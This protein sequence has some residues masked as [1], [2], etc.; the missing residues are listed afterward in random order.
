[1][2]A[3]G[4]DPTFGPELGMAVRSKA[5]SLEASGRAETNLGE[6]RAASGDR[7][8]TTI[9]SGSIIS[10]AHLGPFSGCSFARVGAFQGRAPQVVAPVLQSSLFAALGLRAAYTLPVGSILALRGALEGGLPLVRTSLVIDGRAV[11]TSPP[12]FA[13]ASLG[14]LLK[15]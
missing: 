7:L 8:E 4:P 10:C 1:S 15:F 3:V 11:W 5:L 13:G 2:L 12:V 9:L 6:T 14:A